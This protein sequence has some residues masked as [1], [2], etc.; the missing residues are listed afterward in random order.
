MSTLLRGAERWLLPVLQSAR[1]SVES[2]QCVY[3]TVA[4]H[5]EPF[6]RA[7]R[8]EAIARMKRWQKEFPASIR[9]FRDADG[10]PPRHT[11][12]YPVEQDDDEVL[13]R[14][15]DLCQQT[16]SEVEV[17]LHHEGD[18]AETLRDRLRRG[19]DALMKHGLLRCAADGSPRF[20]FVHGDWAL[21]N[22]HPQGKHCGVH[23]EISVLRRLGCLADMTFPSAPSATQPQRVNS[24]YRTACTG[25]PATL[26]EGPAAM[27]GAGSA[28]HESLDHLLIIQGV[29]ALN[30]GRR[31][32]GLLP[33]LEN[34]DITLA[35]PP[36]AE[37]W[38]LWL[39]RAPRLVGRPEC[40]FI[41]LHTHGATPWNSDMFLGAA[42]LDF[43]SYLAAQ[44]IP[45]HCVSAREMVET[46]HQMEND[47][48]F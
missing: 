8:S 24:I 16:G 30:W 34:S 31:K 10:R 33:R 40:A 46:I 23:D 41:K 4:D 37:R 36:T 43:R 44:S 5:F 48:S 3:L 39:E 38:R 28:L 15:S 11:F 42:M 19:L 27:A 45:V 13:Q 17:H 22:S 6:H 9:G 1:Y 25:N 29:L 21:A 47:I 7:D 2:V 18:T 20:C 12:F 26:S 14:L 32:W 35:N